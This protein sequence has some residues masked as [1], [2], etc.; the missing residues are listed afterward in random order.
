MSDFFEERKK[1][2]IKESG[3][4]TRNIDNI[5]LIPE[6]KDV[7]AF[8]ELSLIKNNIVKFV[9]DGYNLLIFSNN[10]GNGKTTWAC[11]LGLEYINYI[12]KFATENPFLYL[13]LPLYFDIRKASIQDKSLCENVSKTEAL[14]KK[15][16]LVIFDDIGIK[17]LTEY[18]KQLFYIWVEHRTSNK[19]SCIYTSNI[20]P[21]NFINIFGPRISDRIVGYSTLIEIK[22]QSRRNDTNFLEVI[23]SDSTSDN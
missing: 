13:N 2:I 4:P 11:K 16:K 17:D 10:P 8:K 7:E 15:A 22:G 3:I 21:H 23:K 5:Q 12:C 6:L 14:I 19:K 9:N 18:E 1:S 20:Y